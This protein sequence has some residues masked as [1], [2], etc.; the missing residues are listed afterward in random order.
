MVD[1][2][3]HSSRRRVPRRLVVGVAAVVVAASSGCTAAL[4][5]APTTTWPPPAVVAAPATAAGTAGPTIAPAPVA[6]AG[7]AGATTAPAPSGLLPDAAYTPGATN[8]A[9]TQATIAETICLP[10]WT[11]TVRPPVSYT[12]RVKVLEDGGGGTVTYQGVAY[13]VHGFRLGDT[14]VSHFELDHLIS[15]ELGGSPADPRN[16]W[17]QPYEA[18]KG[19]APAGTG[20]Q[21][22]DKVENA[23][24][25]A[26]CAGRLPLADAQQKMATNWATFGRQLGVVP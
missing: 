14:T 13:S 6:P 18:P 11:A 8:P 2:M 15:L 20:S 9:V 22:K 1:L 26:V 12:E 16:L 21:T 23:A 5:T 25:A 24:R 17:L 7:T 3:V 4:S 10:G 19:P